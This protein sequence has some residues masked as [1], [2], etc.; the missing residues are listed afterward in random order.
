MWIKILKYNIIIM[1]RELI[2]ALGQLFNKC[3]MKCR[4]TCCEVELDMKNG[5]LSNLEVMK[6][7]KETQTGQISNI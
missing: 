7:D 5:S 3:R 4:S 6:Q 2:Q 1:W